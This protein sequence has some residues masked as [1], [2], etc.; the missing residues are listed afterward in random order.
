MVKQKKGYTPTRLT[1]TLTQRR[2]FLPESNFACP[3][4]GSKDSCKIRQVRPEHTM[5]VIETMTCGWCGLRM[6]HTE[7]PVEDWHGVMHPHVR[8]LVDVYNGFVGTFKEPPKPTPVSG[9]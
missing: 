4:C 2:R 7:K 5:D 3:K 8:D 1:M 6:E 9:L